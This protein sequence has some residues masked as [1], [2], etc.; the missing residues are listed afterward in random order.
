LKKYP[1]ETRERASRLVRD[2]LADPPGLSVTR[3]C[4]LIGEQLG[5]N[6]DPAAEL[7]STPSL[8]RGS[9]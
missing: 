5:I 4:R 1:D 6:P 3:R 7:L 2:K 9:I 8:L